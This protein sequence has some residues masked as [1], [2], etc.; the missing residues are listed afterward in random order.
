MWPELNMQLQ[1]FQDNP[2]IGANLH[3]FTGIPPLPDIDEEEEKV[4][5]VTPEDMD[6]YF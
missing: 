1:L 3:M 4:N 6:T 2:N 5:F